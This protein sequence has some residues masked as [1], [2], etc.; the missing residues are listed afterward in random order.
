V[1]EL[2][3]RDFAK[4]LAPEWER[5]ESQAGQKLPFIQ[6]DYVALWLDILGK[7]SQPRVMAA[8][9]DGRLAGYAPFMEV[10]GSAGLLNVPTVRFVGNNLTLPGDILFVDVAAL[11]PRTPI[12]KAIL[13]KLKEVRFFQRWDFGF[14]PPWS[15][16]SQIARAILNYGD[17]YADPPAATYVTL[18][19]PSTWDEYLVKVGRKVRQNYRRALRALEEHGEVRVTA[20]FEP[21]SVSRRVDQMIRNHDR[22]SKGTLREREHWFGDEHVRRFYVEG[23]RLLA[24][25]GRYLTFTLQLDDV[26]IAWI[27]GA[28]DGSRYY[29]MMTS[30]DES[31]KSCSPGFVLFMEKMR[32]LIDRSFRHVELTTGSRYY[33]LALG[34]SPVKYARVWGYPR[35]PKWVLQSERARSFLR[36]KGISGSRRR[37]ISHSSRES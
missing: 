25:H 9:S 15:P 24:S 3:E 28:T 29:A 1:E 30:F 20:E 18:E 26:P 10:A 16:T 14:L 4:L 32:L 23:A 37:A 19:L 5:F 7:S 11:E 21:E 36:F 34:G 31:F 33:K 22:W 2:Q 12:V 17:R 6:P 35:L 8:W 27:T 13:G